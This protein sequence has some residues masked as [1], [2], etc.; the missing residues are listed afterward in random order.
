MRGTMPETKFKLPKGVSIDRDFRN[1]QPRYYFRASGQPKVRLRETP[2]TKEFDN[3]VACARLGVA[4]VK[5]GTVEPPP[6]LIRK[7]KTGTFEWLATE[8]KRRI[9][10]KIN[11]GLYGRRARMYEEICDSKIG[12]TRRGDLPFAQMQR[13]HVIEIR[14][15]L[16]DTPGARN[17]VIKT[18]SALFSWAIEV[19]LAETNPATKIKALDVDKATHTWTVEEIGQYEEVHG[20]GTRARLMLHLA[21][22]TGLRLSDLA[23]VGRQHVKNGWLSIRPGKTRKSS[24]AVVELP[25]LPTL[26]RTIDECPTGNLTFLTTEFNKPFTVNGLG[27]KMR[28]WCDQAQLFHC[29]THGLRKAGASIAAENGA[30]DEE[31]MAIYGWVTKSQ[32][33]TYTKNANRKKIA[34]RAIEKLI[35]EQKGTQIVPQDKG[36]PKRGTK[37]A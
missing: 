6:I 32:T 4:Y 29:S 36:L 15:E 34:A 1:R 11:P 25:V 3:E 10:D 14:D 8:Y 27:N 13:R 7:P 9:G 19:G 28:D 18:V 37:T 5:P 20:P 24:G 31:L 33:A 35:P 2:G 16:R 17:H 30:T 21:M 26:Q 22:Y 23:V 12:E